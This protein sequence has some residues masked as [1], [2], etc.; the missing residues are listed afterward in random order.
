MILLRAISAIL[1]SKA[2]WNRIDVMIEPLFLAVKQK[3]FRLKREKARK[4]ALKSKKVRALVLLHADCRQIALIV[5]QK[6]ILH[7]AEDFFFK[8]LHNASHESVSD[9]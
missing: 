9:Q 2:F 5:M 1:L 3:G 7:K 6:R 8:I 4:I